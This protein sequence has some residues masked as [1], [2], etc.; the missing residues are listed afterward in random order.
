MRGSDGV[1]WS[2]VVDNSA[3]YSGS[4]CA[5][6]H[7]DIIKHIKGVYYVLRSDNVEDEDNKLN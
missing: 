4:G 5:R 7:G 2:D 6:P 1:L 3:R